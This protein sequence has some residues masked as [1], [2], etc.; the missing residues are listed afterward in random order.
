VRRVLRW[1][2]TLLATTPRL[3]RTA[4][5]ALAL[6]PARWADAWF[7]PRSDHLRFF[8]ARALRRLL[9]DA[10]F[11]EIEV[12]SAGGRRPLSGAWHVRAS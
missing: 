11:A 6:G 10:G 1:G 9:A 4:L 8:A 7:D 12:A 2:G 5:L 3:D